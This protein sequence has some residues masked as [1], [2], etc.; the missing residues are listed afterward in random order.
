MACWQDFA[1]NLGEASLPV[2]R[3]CLNA[4]MYHSLGRLFIIIA[5]SF[6]STE[7]ISVMRRSCCKRLLG[8]TNGGIAWIHRWCKEQYGVQS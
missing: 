4:C 7:L 8:R 6:Q 3:G 2:L 5:V 1:Q